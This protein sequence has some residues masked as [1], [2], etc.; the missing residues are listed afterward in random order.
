MNRRDA[1]RVLAAIGATGATGAAA[2]RAFAQAPARVR[3]IGFLT[4]RSQPVPPAR[5]AFFDA[6]EK[7]MRVLGYVEGKN[8]AIERRYADGKSP[9]LAEFAAEL[10]GLKV[11]VIVAYGTAAVKAAQSATGRIPIVIAAAVDPVGSGLVASLARPGG[12]TTGLSAIGVD[13]SPKHLELLRAVLPRLTRVALLVNPDNASNAAVEKNVER[14]ANGFGIEVI[15]VAARSPQEIPMA[16]E[17]AARHKAGAVIVA[18]D[19]FFSGQGAL[20]A[21][22]SVRQRMPSIG[23]YETHVKAG[24]L[25]SYGQ[26][27]ADYHRQSAAFVDRI[28]KGAK[29]ADLPVEQPTRIDFVI[30]AKTAR[31]L[32]LAIPQ[33]ILLRADRVIE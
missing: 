1:L 32:G 9:L 25:M 3:L 29:P 16:F 10:A 6:F 11:E 26:D 2:L 15:A 22:A 14:A 18:G 17:A 21:E 5:D 23:I 20:L 31:A 24:A 8:L 30:N 19:A 7:G 4:P 33:S 13:L 12:N 28:L 27:I